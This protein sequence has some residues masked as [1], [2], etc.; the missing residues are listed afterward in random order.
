MAYLENG[1]DIRHL[2]LVTPSYAT[3]NTSIDDY[4]DRPVY[5]Y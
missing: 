1:N 5:I 2:S 4:K 3:E